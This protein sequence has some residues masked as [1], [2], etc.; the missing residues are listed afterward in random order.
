MFKDQNSCYVVSID[1]EIRKGETLA[2]VAESA[3]SDKV[4]KYTL[5]YQQNGNH[6]QKSWNNK[7]VT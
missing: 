3:Y 4:Y 7:K 6:Y 1:V 2:S 5:I